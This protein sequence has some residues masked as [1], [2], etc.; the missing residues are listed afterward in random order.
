MGIKGRCDM[1]KD[2]N[3]NCEI[4]SSVGEPAV[5]ATQTNEPFDDGLGDI[6]QEDLIIPRLKI[7]Q[8]QSPGDVAGK[9]FL[10][11]SGDTMDTMELVL[12]RMNKSRVL[13]PEDFSRDSKPL[14]RSQDFKCPET[15]N[16]GFEPMAESCAEC[17]YGKWTKGSNG[18]S[19]PPRCNEVWNFLVLDYETY[20]PAWF[21]LKSTA[22]KPARKIV[23]MLKLRGTA[24]L[25]PSWHFRFSVEVEMR[26]GAAGDSF[27]PVF[28]SLTLLDDEDRENMDIIQK[29]LAGEQVSFEDTDSPESGESVE[30]F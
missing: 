16:D 1:G 5:P 21:S 3:D 12:L 2:N 28:S 15:N 24:K 19:K 10:D 11:I 29:Q 14:C 25:I 30:D 13:F 17:P 18:S 26:S 23:S 20:M 27:V 6:T 4:L 22:I 7:G 9:L 8:R